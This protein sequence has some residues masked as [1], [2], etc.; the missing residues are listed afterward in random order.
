MSHLVVP[1]GVVPW[2]K[3]GKTFRGN[4]HLY[5]CILGVQMTGGLFKVG[6]REDQC[7]VDGEDVSTSNLALSSAEVAVSRCQ[8]KLEDKG[9]MKAH[10]G[11][12]LKAAPMSRTQLMD[13]KCPVRAV[14]EDAQSVCFAVQC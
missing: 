14:I 6:N 2:C 11:S 1:V 3:Y 10:A 5:Q 8:V 7:V 4:Q 9:A 12:N 13:K